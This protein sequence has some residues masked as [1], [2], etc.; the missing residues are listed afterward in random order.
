MNCNDYEKMLL[1]HETSESLTEHLMSCQSCQLYKKLIETTPIEEA[2]TASTDMEKYFEIATKKQSF[3]DK[4]SLIAF[5]ILAALFL[6][7]TYLMMDFDSILLS[8]G[9]LSLFM[10]VSAL[11][12]TLIKKKVIL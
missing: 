4:L 5:M 9:I 8:Q 2:I 6:T 10:P 7:I 11:V 12:I 3:K 1:H